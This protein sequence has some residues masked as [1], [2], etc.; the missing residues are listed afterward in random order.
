MKAIVMIFLL[1]LSVYFQAYCQDLSQDSLVQKHFTDQEITHLK[2][3]T[4]SFEA[5]INKIT[6]KEGISSYQAYLRM[7]SLYVTGVLDY[8][9]YRIPAEKA[10]QILYAL[11][12]TLFDKMFTYSYQ[13]NKKNK[14]P[15]ARFVSPK[16]NGTYVKLGQE[17]GRNSEFWEYYFNAVSTAGDISPSALATLPKAASQHINLNSERNQLFVA[18]HYLLSMSPKIDM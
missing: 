8:T 16:V 4:D 17:V 11:D 2:V 15:S 9:S 3:L 10:K 13:M 18:L 1:V 5:Q 6:H 7:D 14:Q 12:T